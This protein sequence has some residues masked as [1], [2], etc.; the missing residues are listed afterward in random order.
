[1]AHELPAWLRPVLE[2]VNTVDVEEG[3]DQLAGGPAALAAWLGGSG[4][5]GAD[6]ST[7]EATRA[8]HRLALDLR[9]GLRRLTLLNNGGPADAGD[10]ARLRGALD[11]LPLVAAAP[12][13]GSVVPGLRPH[14]P[15]AVRAALGGLVAGYA[16]AVGTGHWAR[17]RRCPADD[18][19]WV[20]W[21]SSAKGTRRWCSM[22]VC[23][24]RAKARAFA[25]RR[26][27]GR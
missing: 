12:M 7:V 21:D 27:R 24:N 5:A 26:S 9:A 17:M 3:T 10:L 8:D 16:A 1:M 11:R 25:E 2:F 23:G 22:K 4:L 6:G 18:C 13:E 19:A 20:F 14:H 15:S